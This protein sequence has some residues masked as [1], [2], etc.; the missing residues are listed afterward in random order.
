[1]TLRQKNESRK[2]INKINAENRQQEPS[3]VLYFACACVYVCVCMC[4]RVCV[5]N[6]SLITM[7]RSKGTLFLVGAQRRWSIFLTNGHVFDQNFVRWYWVSM[8]AR[9]CT[10][11]QNETNM[12]QDTSTPV[13]YIFIK[14]SSKSV[15]A[16]APNFSEVI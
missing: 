2:Q 10:S 1:M 7:K 14:Y 5:H 15:H 6:P 11:H 3:V 8:Y 12:T 16:G 13:Q 9:R 4:V